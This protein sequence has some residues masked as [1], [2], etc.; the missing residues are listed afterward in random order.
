MLDH[1][2]TYIENIVTLISIQAYK[3]HSKV[4]SASVSVKSMVP[5]YPWYKVRFQYFRVLGKNYLI[6]H[7][8]MI[9]N[10]QGASNNCSTMGEPNR[11]YKEL[12]FN[13]NILSF[14]LPSS[15]PVGN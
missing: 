9:Q 2:Q 8:N 12:N 13:P 10:L 4:D 1:F 3:P 6:R 14:L 7:I 15:V 5:W 11:G